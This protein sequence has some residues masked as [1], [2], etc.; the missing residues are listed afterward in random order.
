MCDGRVAALRLQRD[1]VQTACC[2]YWNGKK[3]EQEKSPKRC[4]ESWRKEA[5]V[6]PSAWPHSCSTQS[7]VVIK[8]QQQRGPRAELY[9][10]L[11]RARQIAIPSTVGLGHE[12]LPNFE[13]RR[14]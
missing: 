11:Y 13:L 14:A 6:R 2:G 9:T 1:G 8:A 10:T 7:T 12:A 3:R 4:Y 5:V